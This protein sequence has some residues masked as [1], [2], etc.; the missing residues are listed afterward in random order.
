MYTRSNTLSLSVPTKNFGAFEY[1]PMPRKNTEPEV[2]TFDQL[3][4]Q[5][6]RAAPVR[7]RKKITRVMYPSNVRKYLPPAEKS[8]AKRWL[9]ALCLVV[10]VQIYTEEGAVDAQRAADVH[11]D[12]PREDASFTLYN[13]LPFQSAEERVRQMTGCREDAALTS[14]S[15]WL[16]ATCP[17]ASW[18][19]DVRAARQQSRRNGYVVALLYPVYHTLG[20]EQ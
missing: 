20:S 17:S 2:F 5:A 14:W 16:N 3:P 11:A 10:L 8:P 6:Q 18:E 12:L 1:K 7:P 9:L 19:E 15:P 4:A 13:V